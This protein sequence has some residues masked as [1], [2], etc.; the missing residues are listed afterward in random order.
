MTLN[1]D[2]RLAKIRDDLLARETVVVVRSDGGHDRSGNPRRGFFARFFDGDD[3]HASSAWF[4][5]EVDVQ[6]LPS[7]YESLMLGI[8]RAAT[9]HVS[10]AEFKRLSKAPCW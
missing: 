7:E 5:H 2:D 10:A 3:E 8:R 4:I 9:V 6:D 1:V